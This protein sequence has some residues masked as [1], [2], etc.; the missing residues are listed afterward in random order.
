ML[1]IENQNYLVKVNPVGAEL[2]GICA[3]KDGYEYMWQGDPA[4][5]KGHSPLLFPVVGKLVGDGYRYRGQNYTMPKHGFLSKETFRIS[6]HGDQSLTLVFDQWEKYAGIYPFRYRVEVNFLLSDASLWI[7]HIVTNCQQAPMYFSLGAHP[8]FRCLA[9]GYVQFP[10]KEQVQAWR[11][12][13]QKIIAK[14]E[15]F[16][17]GESI[18]PIKEDT[19]AADAYV[20]EDVRSPF[21][22][23]RNPAEGKSVKVHLGGAPYLGIWAK[24]AAPYVCIEPWQGLDDDYNQSGDLEDKKG[25]IRLL[26]GERHIFTYGIE[27]QAE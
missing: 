7:S 13:D 2:S 8:A 3:K 4:I 25:I 26:P 24:P 18:F 9:G 1:T 6:E 17:T 20:L 12:D 10:L 21:V 15:P 11:F 27:P 22:W 16:L 23:V 19:F 5:W 14:R